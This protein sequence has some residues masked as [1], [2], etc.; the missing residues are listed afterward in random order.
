MRH[1]TR[2]AEP[3]LPAEPV[4]RPASAGRP[5]SDSVRSASAGRPAV[6]GNA[7][8]DCQTLPSADHGILPLG[9]ITGGHQD[10]AYRR[11]PPQ[12]S[13]GWQAVR[14]LER[15]ADNHDPARGAPWVGCRAHHLLP[16]A[17]SGGGSAR[18]RPQRGW[19][20][21]SPGS[22][23]SA[24]ARRGLY[25]Q[26]PAATSAAQPGFRQEQKACGWSIPVAS[27]SWSTRTPTGLRS[28]R[29]PTPS[30]IPLSPGSP[31]P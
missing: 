6:P 1:R 29:S 13:K 28:L 26:K 15:R 14:A 11:R 24:R 20:P 3:V 16:S 12:A 10:S 18:G 5:N 21:T 22:R 27:G 30:R 31:C 7:T 9:G 19:L 8:G 23:H 2:P 25:C 17:L 4:H